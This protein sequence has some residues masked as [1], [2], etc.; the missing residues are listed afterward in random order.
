MAGRQQLHVL[1]TINCEPPGEKNNSNA[2][3]TWEQSARSIEGFGTRLLRAGYPPTLFVALTCLEE[4][5]PLI[6]ELVRRGAEAA[7]YLHPP[8]IGDGRF[9]RMLGQY[10]PDD[11]RS[12]IEYAAERFTE[13]LRV[14]PRSFRSG[15][16]S[17]NDA[18]YRLLFELGFRQGSLSEPGR[19]L[20]VRE[21]VW[22]E[23]PLDPHYVDPERK[24]RAGDL[25]FLELPVTTDPSAELARGLPYALQIEAG[26][27]DGLHRPTIEGQL[28]RMEREATRF[29][30]LCFYTT[31]RID[32]YRD[33][34]QHSQT[35]EGVLDLLEKLSEQYEIVPVT[36]ASAHDHYRAL[37]R[38]AND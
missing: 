2:P 17:A 18:T 9:S 32:Y 35:I 15:F 7:L 25:P 19:R 21:A 6:E 20:P 37:L 33:D 23:A 36:A 4:Q 5:E 12:L 26:S 24:N 13:I 29:R 31:N 14:R 34:N 22:E 30:T 10:K 28:L 16:F 3:R 11:Q 38:S 1:F 8:Q 27:V